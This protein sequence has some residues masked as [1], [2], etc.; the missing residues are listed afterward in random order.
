M[1]FSIS[2]LPAGKEKSS[3]RML[4][5]KT[6]WFTNHRGEGGEVAVLWLKVTKHY[7]YFNIQSPSE[8]KIKVKIN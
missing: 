1:A 6:V 4:Q 5:N 8:V 2:H 7:F 3:K